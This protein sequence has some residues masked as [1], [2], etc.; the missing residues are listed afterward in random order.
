MELTFYQALANKDP[1][2]WRSAFDAL[3]PVAL[4][5]VKQGRRQTE[6]D[7]PPDIASRAI[8]LVFGIINSDRLGERLR[9]LEKEEVLVQLQAITAVIARR[10]QI[11]NQRSF[12]AAKRSGHSKLAPLEDDMLAA[13]DCYEAL[14]LADAL[15]VLREI[16]DQRL[17]D[18]ER[19]II[20]DYYMVG[21]TLAEISKKREMPLGSVGTKISRAILKVRDRLDE[22]GIRKESLKV[23]IGDELATFALQR[24]SDD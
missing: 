4:K 19:Q 5:N 11:S 1:K 23:F 7:D 10:I 22:S 13:K 18:T 21:L 12:Y 3:F 17:D 14:E 6:L 16:M 9:G 15:R 24:K 20:N 8:S 2:A